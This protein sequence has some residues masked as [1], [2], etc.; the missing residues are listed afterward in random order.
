MSFSNHGTLSFDKVRVKGSIN[1]QVMYAYAYD[2]M[3]ISISNRSMQ[4]GL[5]MH[6]SLC[7]RCTAGFYLVAGE[8]LYSNY[9]ICM[10]TNTG[11][12]RI[13][14]FMACAGKI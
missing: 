9:T 1:S 2:K 14:S 7:D 5:W 4:A 10:A 3:L 6:S 11:H 13:L 12:E 8:L